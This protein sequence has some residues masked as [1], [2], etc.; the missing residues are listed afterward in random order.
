[1]VEDSDIVPL[2]LLEMDFSESALLNVM[3]LVRCDGEML[4]GS[5]GGATNSIFELLIEE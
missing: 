3:T 2:I 5:S 1:M 4:P